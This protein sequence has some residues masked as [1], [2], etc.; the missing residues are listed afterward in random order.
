MTKQTIKSTAVEKYLDTNGK[1]RE[2]FVHLQATKAMKAP[3]TTSVFLN[4]AGHLTMKVGK[5]TYTANLVE[6]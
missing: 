4:K 6:D 2:R 5:H 3:A 1:T